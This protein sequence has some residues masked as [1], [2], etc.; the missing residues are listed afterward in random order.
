MIPAEAEG[1]C[2]MTA[3]FGLQPLWC[4]NYNCADDWMGN[5][6]CYCN[7]KPYSLAVTPIKN[8]H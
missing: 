3:G 8:S 5:Y 6:I 7:K 1:L 4:T 2:A